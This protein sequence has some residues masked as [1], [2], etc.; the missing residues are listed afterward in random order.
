MKYLFLLLA[1]TF[2]HA[3]KPVVIV[4][5]PPYVEFVQRIAGDTVRIETAL[6]PGF[7]P[8]GGETTPKH[9]QALSKAAVWIGTGEPFE[10]RFVAVLKENNP[11]LKVVDLSKS[12]P[13]ITSCHGPDLHIWTSPKLAQ[14]QA[15][16][17]AE[18]LA[19]ITST[20]LDPFLQDLRQLDSD[21]TTMLAPYRGSAIL[22]THPSLAYFCQDYGLEELSVECEGKHAKPRELKDLLQAAQEKKVSCFLT[23]P[24][25]NNKGLLLIARQL[26]KPTYEIDPLRQDYI[27]NMREIAQTI[28]RCNG[29]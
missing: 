16:V 29:K 3:E 21:I 7:D 11:S 4:S 17:I 19:A 27:E 28:A 22:V 2:L 24:Q 13:L 12:V 26:D 9:I 5:V 14:T 15:R 20:S 18:A 1:I 10:Q 6:P 8:H 23:Q 25:F